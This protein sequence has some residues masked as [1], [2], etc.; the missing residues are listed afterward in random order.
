MTA[1]S[2]KRGGV[3]RSEAEQKHQH[4]FDGGDA[5]A[6]RYFENIV[7]PLSEKLPSGGFLAASTH[8]YI[9]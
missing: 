2:K 5:A 4:R 1:K 7:I 6:R 3:A 8:G 9:Q